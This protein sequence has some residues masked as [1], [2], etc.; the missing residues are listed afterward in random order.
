MGQFRNTGSHTRTT[1]TLKLPT[2]R[3]HEIRIVLFILYENLSKKLNLTRN[4]T[5]L[6]T[7][8]LLYHDCFSPHAQYRAVKRKSQGDFPEV[9]AESQFRQTGSS[10]F[11]I[12]CHSLSLPV[13]VFVSLMSFHCFTTLRDITYQIVISCTRL[14]TFEKKIEND[15]KDGVWRQTTV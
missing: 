7:E 14:Y 2:P 5:R 12:F 9:V 15:R 4:V 1:I 11:C 13:T 3:D 6:F 10:R 8:I